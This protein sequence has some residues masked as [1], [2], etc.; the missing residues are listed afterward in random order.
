M[1]YLKLLLSVSLSIL[2]L[3]CFEGKNED[4][5]VKV[6]KHLVTK[7]DLQTGL[8]NLSSNLQKQQIPREQQLQY[9]LNQT[10]QDEI[11]YQE[12]LKSG[13][14]QNN[15]YKDFVQNLENQFSYQKKQGLVELFIREKIDANIAISDQEVATAYDSNKTTLFSK[16]EQRSI[17]QIVVKTEKEARNLLSRL[18]KGSN[19]STLAK[20]KSIDV[21]T[22]KNNGKIP[23]YIRKSDIADTSF[24]KA[25]FSISRVKSYSTKPVKSEAGYHIFR[26]DDIQQVPAKK[27]SDVKDFI[28]NQLYF[29]KRSQEIQNLLTSVKDKYEI[30]QNEALNKQAEEANQKV[31]P[32]KSP[33]S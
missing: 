27:L 8:I 7:T 29:S 15:D 12:A 21:N 14:D 32:T 11:L 23:G 30:T 10:V 18:R 5:V 6:N 25:I 16:Y 19:F 4:W 1:T 33:N 2:L 24:Q 22:G 28:K 20:T 9:V 17:S 31:A 13:L 3:S 26:L